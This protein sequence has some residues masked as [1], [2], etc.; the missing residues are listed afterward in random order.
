MAKD[1][2]PKKNVN[3]MIANPAVCRWDG[4]LWPI[5]QNVMNIMTPAGWKNNNPY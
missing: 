3:P 5:P 1:V 2:I 4:D